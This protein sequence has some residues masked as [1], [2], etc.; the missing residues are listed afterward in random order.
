MSPLFQRVIALAGLVVA[1]PLLAAIG[2][3]VR[4]ESRG[5]IVYRAR[6][7]GS[8]ARPFDCFKFRSM[9]TDVGG[10]SITRRNDLRVTRVGRLLRRFRLDEIPQLFNVVR[11]EMLLV[12]PRP[13]D[14][15]FVDLRDPLHREVF[16][17]TPGITGLSQLAFA[18]EADLLDPDD[19]EGSYRSRVLPCKVALDAR[20]LARRSTRLDCWIL[21][22][23]I[24]AA[25]GGGPTLD[26][27][28][29]RL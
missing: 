5:P 9:R 16:S 14:P 29:A 2:L 17:A 23:T 8:G 1:A 11:G 27:I 13:E 25:L 4:L 28:E 18:E 12:G 19:P 22:R 21:Y 26:E 6:R 15:R 20:Y 10:G 24:G 3:A 7:V